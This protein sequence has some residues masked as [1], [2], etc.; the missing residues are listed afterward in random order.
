MKHKLK[1]GGREERRKIEY[2]YEITTFGLEILW[3]SVQGMTGSEVGKK[4]LG[5]KGERKTH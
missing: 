4:E 5:L 2:K 3:S 1:H